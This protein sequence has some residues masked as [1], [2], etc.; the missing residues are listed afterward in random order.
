[1]E[2]AVQKKPMIL[3]LEIPLPRRLRF[4]VFEA[5]QHSSER[6]PGTFRVQL[7]SGLPSNAP[8]RLVFDRGGQVRPILIGLVIELN[9]FI[10]WDAELHDSAGGFPYSKGVQAPPDIVWAALASGLSEGSRRLRSGAMEAIVA[11]RPEYLG[12]ALA[13]RISLSNR[14]L[15]GQG[16]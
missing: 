14:S 16:N 3:D 7:T 2:A 15:I 8:N 4:Y 11:S 12:A 9:V 5:T 6:Q 1:M 13:R 10:I